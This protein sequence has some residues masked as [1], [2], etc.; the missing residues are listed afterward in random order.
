MKVAAAG[1]DTPTTLAS[2]Q[3][4]PKAIAVDSSNVYW[5]NYSQSPPDGGTLP[6][7]GNGSVMKVGLGG[8]GL[9]TLASGQDG[10][11]AIAIDATNVYWNG[12]SADIGGSLMKIALGGGAPTTFAVGLSRFVPPIAVDAN[13]LYW[14][15]GTA[16]GVMKIALGGGAAVGLCSGYW[17][18]NDSYGVAIDDTNAYWVDQGGDVMKVPLVGGTPVILALQRA[19]SA[20]LAVDAT[21]VYFRATTGIVKVPK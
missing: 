4:Y 11:N 10:P 8:S 21:S 12:Y 5:A 14:S 7:P 9:T 18:P 2:G 19:S 6:V 13:D 17:G 1:G 16:S 15:S 20:A 3:T